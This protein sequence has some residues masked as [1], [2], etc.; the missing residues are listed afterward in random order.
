MLSMMQSNVRG[1]RVKF[2]K[3]G[4]YVVLAKFFL[5]ISFFRFLLAVLRRR[6]FGE[7]VVRMQRVSR[8]LQEQG[9]CKIEKFGETTE[10]GRVEQ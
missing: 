1:W 2:I 7:M 5:D 3:S 4:V 10:N 9:E 6:F 8:S